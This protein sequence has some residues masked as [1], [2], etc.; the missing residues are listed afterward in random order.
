LIWNKLLPDSRQRRGS[1]A[2][3]LA[4]STHQVKLLE[5]PMSAALISTKGQIV[6]PDQGD[7]RDRLQGPVRT[8]GRTALRTA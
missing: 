6:L 7:A 4:Y 3:R 1:P 2:E 8:E 5:P